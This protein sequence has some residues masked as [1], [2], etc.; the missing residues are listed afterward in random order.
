MKTK[1]TRYFLAILAF[2]LLS[3]ATV[4][5][6]KNEAVFKPYWFMQAQVGGAY[7][8][9]E[10]SS[11]GKLISPAAALNVGRRM[12]PWLGL[13]AG[14]SGWQ[15]KG[16]MVVPDLD[17]KFSY[18]QGN[19]DAIAS[20][21]SLCC[22][23]SA[24]RTLDVYLGVGIGGAYGFDNKEA[25]NFNALN[26]EFEKLWRGHRWFLA[27]RG[28][29]GME[30]NLSRVVALNIEA[31][32]NLLPDSWNSKNGRNEDWQFNALVGLTVKFGT[33]RKSVPVIV[34]EVVAVEPEPVVEVVPEP[35]AVEEPAPAPEPVKAEKMRREVFFL[36]NSSTVRP[37]EMPKVMSLAEFMKEHPDFK[38]TVTGYADKETGTGP[39]NMTLSEKRAEAVAAKLKELGIDPSRIVIAAE[40]DTVQPYGPRE[41]TK[42]R[43]AI[44]ISEQ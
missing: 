24:D 6:E 16:Y 30:I 31:N 15:G 3:G 36:I 29:L 18:A 1:L 42:N 10:T 20:L 26:G 4:K 11:M 2:S 34:E 17:Y 27:G 43:V 28:V 8:V 37:E 19:L 33:A 13:R 44:C 39:Y 22:G 41:Y 12:T 32:A 21:T 7:T 35:V 25:E 14:L 40:G 5:A 9:G 23:Y 38:V